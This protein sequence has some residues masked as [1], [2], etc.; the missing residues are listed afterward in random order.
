M[1]LIRASIDETVP[2]V[3][4]I[5]TLGPCDPIDGADIIQCQSEENLILDW[6]HFVTSIDPD[7]VVGYKL[8]TQDLTRVVERANAIFGGY[9]LRLGRLNC[10]FETSMVSPT[11][12]L[13]K[14]IYRYRFK[15]LEDT[16]V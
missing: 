9:H 13:S 6:S 14:T 7:V 5:F 10:T 2:F 12:S 15:G 16:Y 3:Q 11:K 1:G 4:A 8:D